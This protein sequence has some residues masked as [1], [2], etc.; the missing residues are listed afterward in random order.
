MQT[1]TGKMRTPQVSSMWMVLARLAG[2]LGELT[3]PPKTP[4]TCSEHIKRKFLFLKNVNRK[5]SPLLVTLKNFF[6]FFKEKHGML[7]LPCLTPQ[8]QGK[9]YLNGC[10]FSTYLLFSSS[11]LSNSSSEV[12]FSLLIF[13]APFCGKKHR[14]F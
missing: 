6:F 2:L 3:K 11:G 9:R 5:M 1:D 13:G 4:N 12:S 8:S 10:S 14:I 7:Y